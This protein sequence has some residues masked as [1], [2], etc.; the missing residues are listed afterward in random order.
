[1]IH[2]LFVLHS[3]RPGGAERQLVELIKGLDKSV[4]R[5]SVAINKYEETGYQP[6]LE[7]MNIPIYCFRRKHK[8]DLSP[9]LQIARLIKRE[10]VD[11]VHSFLVLGSVF[12]TI[13]AK[14]TS[15]PIVCS[16]L[17]TARD[18]NLREVLL[19][20]SLSYFP[21]YFVSNSMAG[22]KSRFKKMRN[23]FK[24]VYNGM[25]FSRFSVDSERQSRIKA[26]FGL[27]KWGN[28]V[29]MIASLSHKKDQR[30]LLCSAKLVIEK[31]PDTL[32]IFVGDNVRGRLELLQKQANELCISEN[33]I[34]TGFRSDVDQIVQLL[35]ISVLLTYEKYAEG[36]PNAVIESLAVNKPV[37]ASKGGGTDEVVEDGVTGLLVEPA[38]AIQTASAIIK[39]IEDTR[40]AKTLADNGSALVVQKYALKRY[41]EE[42][43]LMYK[44]LI[45]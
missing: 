28:V 44:T 39:L 31:Y 33:V 22:F 21:D 34:F 18:T 37:I 25:D 35:D 8:Y 36:T 13:S 40:L 41:V 17:R 16:A 19:S 27:A 30:T 5:I 12:G 29:G 11:I 1:M 10:K 6:D 23:N 43:E 26:E 38:S 2:I 20:H 4:Y 32:F 24:V 7:A 45:D 3:L 9:V 42:Y 14:L 15:R